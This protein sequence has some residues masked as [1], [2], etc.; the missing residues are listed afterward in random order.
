MLNGK[1]VRYE[2][3]CDNID[4]QLALFKERIDWLITPVVISSERSPEFFC[5]ARQPLKRKRPELF[6]R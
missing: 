1:Y 2:I 5:H 6:N 4:P 3:Y